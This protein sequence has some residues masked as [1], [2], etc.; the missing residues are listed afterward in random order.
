MVF[1]CSLLCGVNFGEKLFTAFASL[2]IRRGYFTIFLSTFLSSILVE[3]VLWTALFQSVSPVYKTET[4]LF[5]KQD[6]PQQDG[7]KKEHE[8]FNFQWEL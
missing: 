3:F 2:I 7:E 8:F 6:T 4:L 1:A 5:M